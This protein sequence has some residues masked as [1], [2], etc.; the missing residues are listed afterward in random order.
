MSQWFVNATRSVGVNVRPSIA[1]KQRCGAALLRTYHGINSAPRTQTYLRPVVHIQTRAQNTHTNPANIV[2]SPLPA[3][4][5][6]TCTVPELILGISE[7]V[8]HKYGDTVAF[9]MHGEGSLTYNEV[10]RESIEFGKSVH[11][12]FKLSK[13][14]VAA[15]LLPN[16]LEFVPVLHGLMSVGVI[17]TTLNPG[18]TA[19]EI[20]YQLNDSKC[21]AVVIHASLLDKFSNAQ[22][23]LEKNV[24]HVV[25]VG[26]DGTEQ[27]PLTN[28]HHYKDVVTGDGSNLPN[29]PIDVHRDVAL[30]PYSSGTTGKPKGVKLTHYN[31]CSN[32]AQLVM[33]DQALIP[34]HPNVRQLALLPMFHIYGL[35]MCVNIG[36]KCGWTMSVMNGFEPIAFLET[37]Q[38]DKIQIMHLVPPLFI[39]LAKHPMVEKYDLSSLENLFSGAAPLTK[40]IILQVQDRLPQ[41]NAIR[42]LYGMTEL[43]PCAL[44]DRDPPTIGSCG[45]V[46]PNTEVKFLDVHTQ[47]EVAL[48]EVGELCVRG[49]QVM[50]GYHER[51]EETASTMTH[52]GFLRTGDV[53]KV[54]LNGKVFIL[55]RMKE[56][57]KVK[58]FQ[59]APTEL[60]DLLLSH[61]CVVDSAVIARPDEFAGELP[62]A[63]VVRTAGSS[64]SESDIREWVNKSVS[65]HKRLCHVEF[66]EAIPKNPS[67]KILRRVLRDS[68]REKM[69]LQNSEKK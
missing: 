10:K 35:L 59:V 65:D 51:P 19:T 64:T 54:D 31:L 28:V 41:L 9:R 16:C 25:V 58:G 44:G 61:T 17:A 26:G 40:D 24:R 55:D 7:G 38:R 12:D 62:K 69:K 47:Q 56:L 36:L 21:D 4:A 52:D 29:I 57:V 30:L 53:G 50:M 63:F 32:V 67:G 2:R 20:A 18:Y 39:F 11:N 3:V 42:Q 5:I 45:L 66:I 34:P 13:G 27:V 46:I 14:E 43:S 68:E 1:L 49:P 22:K 33:G 60:E 48:G 6:P 15:I 8:Q 37:I 23:L